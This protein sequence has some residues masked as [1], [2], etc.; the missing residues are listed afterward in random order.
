MRCCAS[1]SVTF[2]RE[3]HFI[4]MGVENPPKDGI[5]VTM[6]LKAAYYNKNSQTATQKM[7]KAFFVRQQTIDNY[8]PLLTNRVNYP[9]VYIFSLLA[10]LGKNRRIS[11]YAGTPA[12]LYKSRNK[13]F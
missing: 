5:I 12:F 13:E 8:T 9:I 7:P 6:S 2:F 10:F 1:F 11:A 3:L 4:T